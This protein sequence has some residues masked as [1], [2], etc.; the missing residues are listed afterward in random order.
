MWIGSLRRVQVLRAGF[1]ISRLVD[2][3][4]TTYG[5]MPRASCCGQATVLG[6]DS[7]F[8]FQLFVCREMARPS[9]LCW[10]H[11]NRADPM[12]VSSSCA[13]TQQGKDV[14]SQPR[15]EMRCRP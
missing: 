4:Y 10:S 14:H 3:M 5:L 7:T 15:G 12:L 8:F 2:R 6:C 13:V 11:L 9:Y 1:Q